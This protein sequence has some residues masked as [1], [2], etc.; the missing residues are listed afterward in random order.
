[1]TRSSHSFAKLAPGALLLWALAAAAQAAPAQ[2]QAT[3][4][5]AAAP[6]STAQAGPA[7]APV[8]APVAKAP[9]AKAAGARAAGA[10]TQAALPGRPPAPAPAVPPGTFLADDMPSIGGLVPGPTTLTGYFVDPKGTYLARLLPKPIADPTFEVLLFP[11]ASGHPTR[12]ERFL[13]QVP[14]SPSA[15]PPAE[16]AL[17]LGFHPFSVS[18]YSVYNASGLPQICAQRGW[19]LL[20]PY[21]LT[22]TNMGNPASQAAV[23]AC[24]AWV[25]NLGFVYNQDRVYTAG[26]SMGGLNA[27]SYALRNQ[28]PKGAVRIA[29]VINHT[30]TMDLIDNYSTGTVQLKQLLE[31]PD[32]FGASPT[33]DPFAWWRVN[34][35][36][37]FGQTVDPNT[38]QAINL[39]DL[40]VFLHW[41]NQ[42][43]NTNLV[44][45]NRSL[46]DYLLAQGAIVTVNEVQ[47]GNTHAWATLNMAT[48][49]DYVAAATAP[50][51]GALGGGSAEIF[52]DRQER[53]RMSEVL[54]IEPNTVARYRLALSLSGGNA[55][56]VQGARGVRRLALELGDAALDTTAPLSITS[57]TTDGKP[58]TLVLR[59]YAQAPS[60]VLVGGVPPA[61][62]SH[63]PAT[64]ELVVTPNGTGAFA[65][66]DI[67]P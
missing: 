12:I 18:E 17:V 16:R 46:R 24:L 3:N 32:H 54:E 53:Y 1:M 65:V 34:P 60:Q 38:A 29:G 10:G 20:A 40:R 50:A 64:A 52:A 49:V 6:G 2:V 5:G 37:I 31:N 30:G 66:L 62:L 55:F 25:R 14:A 61:F 45:Y 21:G 11:P 43:P 48:A 28:D 7:A 22:D 47:A 63:D 26:F 58:L 27:V 13:L 56:G 19:Y 36:R 41:N 57:W 35:V 9:V 42:D 4:Q 23:D 51:P 15:P 39:K 8:A 44:K 33:Q 67:Q 59:G